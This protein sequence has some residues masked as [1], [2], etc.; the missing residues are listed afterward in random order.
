MGSRDEVSVLVV[1]DSADLVEAIGLL[2]HS[3][4]YAVRTATDG[5]AALALISEWAPHCVILDVRMPN[6]DGY[7]FARHL[8]AQ[9]RDDIVLIAISG[10][11]AT[12]P[13][14]S[15]TFSIVDHYLQK[16]LDF[17]ELDKI[18]PSL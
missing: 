3:K 17:A 2:L 15:A 18:L 9:Y 13:E 8:R 16:P 10:H 14:V 12:E 7:E 1:D 6:M 11:A 5:A 4:G